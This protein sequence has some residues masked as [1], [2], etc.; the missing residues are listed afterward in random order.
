MLLNCKNCEKEYEAK[1]KRSAYCSDNCK[2]M[3]NRNNSSVTSTDDSSVTSEND[4][5]ETID[6][7]S[8]IYPSDTK[9]DKLFQDD[10]I[11]RNLGE[12]W[13]AFSEIVRMPKCR[14]CNKSFKTRLSLLNYCS[15]TCRTKDLKG[16]YNV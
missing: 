11:K 10:A 12:Y 2:V 13:L 7:I 5:T 4:V 8:T 6:D 3:Y 9:T 15:P 14:V 1:T 16:E